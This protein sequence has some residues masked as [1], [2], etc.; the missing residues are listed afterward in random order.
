VTLLSRRDALQFGGAAL[1]ATTLLGART[2]SLLA[3]QDEPVTLT[4]W[5]YYGG[6][7][8]ASLEAVL[9]KY[10]DEHPN[11]TIEARLVNFPDFNRT[12]LQSAAA[13]DLPDIALINAFDT[14]MLAEAGIITDLTERATE[15]GGTGNYFPGIYETSLWEG[16]NYGL[17]HLA[18]AYV[19]WYNKDIFEEAGLE[20]PKTWDELRETAKALS[21]DGR[22]GIAMSAVEG[23]EGATAYVLR[24]LAAGGDI[25]DID[26]DAGREAMEEIVGLVESGS[27]SPG[28]LGWLEDDVATQF[29][30][31]QAAMMINSASY[32]NYFRSEYPEL[33]SG[34][35]HMPADE[36]STT[37]LNAEHLTITSGSENPDAAWDLIVWMQQPEVLNDYLPKRNK[38]PALK[39]VADEPQWADDPVW[40]VFTSQLEDAWAP[41]GNVAT[42]S[43]EIL[44]Y[45]Q[46]AVQASVSGDSTI[47]EALAAAQVKIDEALAD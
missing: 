35:A 23:L 45:I 28:I 41:T 24:L 32:V 17:P 30:T 33:N 39:N 18:D 31:G 34:L 3:R 22:Y 20:P 38:L 44:T 46:E 36:A 6:A 19:L 12:L 26:S 8:T 40:S 16:K 9:Q 14:Q 25:T 5:H 2:Q 15:W 47:D 4:F 29:A 27:M 42:N 1:V 37:F 7:H 21:G 11:V 13:G 43:A 10:M